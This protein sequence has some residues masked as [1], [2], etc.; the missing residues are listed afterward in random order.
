MGVEKLRVWRVRK[1]YTVGNREMETGIS[2]ASKRVPIFLHDY[3][4]GKQVSSNFGQELRQTQGN[5]DQALGAWPQNAYQMVRMVRW[6][7]IKKN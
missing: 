2:E 5:S 6:L 1:T 4:G 3:R 7:K